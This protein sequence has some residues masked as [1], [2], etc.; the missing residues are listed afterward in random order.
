M[1]LI[2]LIVP[3][4][5]KTPMVSQDK[6]DALR[7]LVQ[8][9]KDAGKIDDF[10]AVLRAVCERED[11]QST[12]LEEGIAVPHGKTDAVPSLRVAVGI[13]PQGIEFGSLDGKPTHLFFLL[14]ASPAQA[15]PHVEALAE[16][17]RLSRSKAFCRALFSAQT[18]KEVLDL[19][20]GE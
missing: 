12:G 4:V 16:V 5:V 14:V 17:A 15:G 2:D 6:A 18:P 9:L 3:E 11:K 8:V 10:E 1:A 13:S 7:E 20:K 19:I